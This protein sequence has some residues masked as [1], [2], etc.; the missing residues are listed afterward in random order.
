MWKKA[1]ARRARRAEEDT[2]GTRIA[3]IVC[4]A[5]LLAGCTTYIDVLGADD[6]AS[7]GDD[8]TIAGLGDDDTTEPGD[9]DTT[10]PGDDDTADDD[11]AD[12]DSAGEGPTLLSTL[13]VAGTSQI[14]VDEDLQRLLVPA[15]AGGN[16]TSTIDL[17]TGA[18]VATFPTSS[19]PNPILLDAVQDRVLVG[20]AS[21]N[22]ITV[23]D[24]H[25][26]A[27]VADLPADANPQHLVANP[28]ADVVYV[29]NH[30]SGAVQV[31]D[32]ATLAVTTGIVLESG[33]RQSCYGDSTLYV[34]GNAGIVHRIDTATLSTTHTA[35]I[36][37]AAYGS[38]VVPAV[39]KLYVSDFTHDTVYVFDAADLTP[40]ST[41]GVP[42]PYQ[43]AVDPA[44][45]TVA[46]AGYGDGSL[47]FVDT[48]AD[49]VVASVAVGEGA[50]D[51]A[52][53]CQT[54]RWYVSCRLDSWVAEVLY[55]APAP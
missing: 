13:A 21:G 22:R 51:V 20:A 38:A 31:I 46:V 37:G 48:A 29:I 53:D 30:D 32:G 16:H 7:A 26:L 4:I 17:S 28:D 9:D 19:L 39:G 44:T 8:D 23:V 11:D 42:E 40:L 6:P 24:R 35:T 5:A 27:Q 49:A 12:D 45:N 2:V 54:S 10:E 1:L 50:T 47:N 41:M 33:L 55:A 14:A 15:Y 52:F 18:E 25:T 3:T 43:M 34:V 36:P